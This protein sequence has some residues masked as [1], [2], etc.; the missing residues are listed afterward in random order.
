MELNIGSLV[1][2][3]LYFFTNQ[4]PLHA[5]PSH[6]NSATTRQWVARMQPGTSS[7]AANQQDDLS[8]IGSKAVEDHESSSMGDNP[9]MPSSLEPEDVFP[10]NEMRDQ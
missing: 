4:E 6:Q 3:Q 5:Q 10:E 1:Y 7:H 2:Q 9:T 8:S